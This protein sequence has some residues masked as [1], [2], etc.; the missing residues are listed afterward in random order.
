MNAD[1]MFSIV[2]KKIKLIVNVKITGTPF[3]FL[4]ALAY[5]KTKSFSFLKLSSTPLL[6]QAM[7]YRNTLFHAC[8]PGVSLWG[9]DI[10]DGFGFG[11]GVSIYG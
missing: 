10:C 7:G 1:I 4:G 3:E 2:I 9:G 8:M 6:L 11:R 5:K